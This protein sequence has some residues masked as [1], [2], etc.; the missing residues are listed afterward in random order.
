[1]NDSDSYIDAYHNYDSAFKDAVSVFKDKAL[2][3]FKMDSGLRIVEPLRTENAKIRSEVEFSDFTFR[4]SNGTG[5][6]LE[7]EIDLDTKDLM[8]FFG[9]HVDLVQIYEYEFATVIFVKNKPKQLEIDMA[10]IKFKP[11]VFDCTEI[12]AD[13]V[14]EKLKRQIENGEPV[15]ELEIIYLPLFK[16]ERYKPTE[17]LKEA[18]AIV[19]MSKMEDE[20]KA[21]VISLSLV[22][23][24]KIVDK[25]VLKSIWEEFRIMMKLKVLEVAEEIGV[26]KGIE[27]G[28]EKGKYEVA[29]SMMADGD[30][31][32]KISR[33]TK[34]P[35]NDLAE[36]FQLEAN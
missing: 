24:N 9:Y 18:A 25:D 26:E 34:I 10:A 22:A 36:H 21:K 2:D 12:N 27:L 13:E 20:M 6:H 15:N 32:E 31:I 17:L 19:K 4:L 16:S 28:V 3:F 8:R 35:I 1:M 7:E 33:N 14:L 5:L 29:E 11:I 23:S 30:S